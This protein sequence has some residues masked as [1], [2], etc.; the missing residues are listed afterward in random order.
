[1]VFKNAIMDKDA[2]GY[3]LQGQLPF[4]AKKT[5]TFA[6]GTLNDPG[7]QNGTHNPLSL[8][9]V[10]GDVLLALFAVAEV[11]PVGSSATLEVGVATATAELLAQT[12]AANILI[13]KAWTDTGPSLAA[14]GL[15]TAHIL[16]RSQTIIQTVGTADIT[17]GKLN[18]YCFWRPLS[19]DGNVVAA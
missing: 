8:F 15:P 18:Y 9:T 11:A 12:T 19:D 5:V 6:G 13:K 17:A 16:G 10:T 4:S 1:M 2:N 3:Q 7:D 14:E